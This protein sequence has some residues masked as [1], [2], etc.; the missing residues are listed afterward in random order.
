[1]RDRI[2]YATSI[3]KSWKEQTPLNPVTLRYGDVPVFLEVAQVIA[4]YQ[5]Q[6]TVGANFAVGNFTAGVVGPITVVGNASAGGT[7][8]DR[9]TV[10]YSPLTGVG[11]LK[12]LMTPIP[13]SAVLSV[14]QS[15]YDANRIMRITLTSINDLHNQSYTLKRPAQPGFVR[16]AQL[17]RDGQLEGALQI[18]I[19]QPNRGGESSVMVFGPSKDPAIAVQGREIRRLLGLRE[20]LHEIMQEFAAVVQAPESDV[21]RG[22][23][24]P[25]LVQG[26]PAGPRA[27]R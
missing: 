12:S 4:G 21:A 3:G 27:R 18:R 16:L 19:G 20:D 8:T 1:M 25:G 22:R 6:S 13:P 14:L 7:Y 26:G 11:F 23:A 2:D 15:G 10:V 5:L 9:P 24:S 17:L